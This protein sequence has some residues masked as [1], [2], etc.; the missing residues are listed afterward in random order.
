MISIRLITVSALGCVLFAS[1]PVVVAIWQ[2]QK[3]VPVI[4]ENSC[5]SIQ[6][7]MTESEVEAILGAPSGDY[8]GGGGTFTYDRD[9]NFFDGSNGYD[10]ATNWWGTLGVIQVNFNELGLVKS[11]QFCRLFHTERCNLW[12]LLKIKS[13]RNRL[14][15]CDVMT[16]CLLM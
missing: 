7:G 2:L 13:Y 4:T 16:R 9:V 15:W 8:T 5:N 11:T 12:D 1:V 3:K 10:D 14:R 6:V